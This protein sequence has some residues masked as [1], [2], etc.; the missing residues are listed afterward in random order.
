[1]FKE[2]PYLVY[3]G[4]IS[5]AGATAVY[6]AGMATG[7]NTVSTSATVLALDTE[8][9]TVDT[10]GNTLTVGSGSGQAGVILNG[11]TIEDST[12]GAG[13]LAFGGAEG[14]IYSGSG[15]GNISSIISGSG[16]ITT[17]G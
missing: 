6:N 13:T 3:S 11:G 14:T 10:D 8:G 17:F 2:Y 7:S 9:Q 4:G 1:G 16:G 5:S 15:N 12:A